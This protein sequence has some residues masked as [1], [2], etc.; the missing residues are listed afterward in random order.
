MFAVAFEIMMDKANDED[1]FNS[2]LICRLTVIWVIGLIG[3]IISQI[4]G[5]ETL[6]R[7]NVLRN[8]NYTMG[9]ICIT[10]MNTVLLGSLAMIPRFMQ[11]MM[12][13]DA[14]TSGLSMMPRGIGCL[15]GLFLN[16]FLQMRVDVRFLASSGILLLALGSWMLGDIN[17]QISQASI[18]IPNVLFGIGM[19]IAM[20]PLVS[21][22]CL[23]VD[24]KEMSNASG[25]QNFIKTIGGAIGTSLVATFISRFSQMHQFMLIKHLNETNDIY[26]AKLAAYSANFAQSIDV[27]IAGYMAQKLI[28]NELLQQSRLWAYIDSFRIYAVVSIKKLMF[29]D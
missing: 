16:K 8:W 24:S 17:L 28:Y 12:G 19:T 22:S 10:V 27:S 20:I 18:F 15:I 1:W 7:F 26:M 11:T 5:K 13:Y 21:F 23:T 2:V 3:F 29:K 6:V 25:L 4:K 14:F 9:T